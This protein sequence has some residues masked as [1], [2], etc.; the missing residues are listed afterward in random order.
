MNCDPDTLRI[1]LPYIKDIALL[2]GLVILG[3]GPFGAMA[4]A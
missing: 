3:C 4:G 1:V 2:V